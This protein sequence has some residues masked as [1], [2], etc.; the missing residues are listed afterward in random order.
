LR[1]CPPKGGLV[2]AARSAMEGSVCSDAL[3][4][5]RLGAIGSAEEAHPSPASSLADF[6]Y[7]VAKASGVGTSSSPLDTS[8]SMLAPG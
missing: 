4:L 6:F 2:E 5:I 7:L 8:T 3:E 1:L